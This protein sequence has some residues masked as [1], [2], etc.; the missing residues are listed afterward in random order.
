[1]AN[2]YLP[3]VV[4][5]PPS[6]RFTAAFSDE[7]E[8]PST[9]A[10]ADRSKWPP[11]VDVNETADA[12]YVEVAV[13]KTT[14]TVTS[15]DV[16]VNGTFYLKV[17]GENRGAGPLTWHGVWPSLWFDVYVTAAPDG[18]IDG[19]DERSDLIGPITVTQAL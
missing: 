7:A 9:G 15:I 14:D 18:D 2:P 4:A 5:T 8:N 19:Y 11:S 10:S 16:T 3:T 13:T 1:M 17:V 6:Q 12:S